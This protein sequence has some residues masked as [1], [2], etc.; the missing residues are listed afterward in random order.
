MTW[1]YIQN[2]FKR[3]EQTT[4][5]ELKNDKNKIS[6]NLLFQALV[7]LQWCSTLEQLIY[8]KKKCKVFWFNWLK[9]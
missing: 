3:K 7:K 5:I 9:F 6:K 2:I 8:S 4:S 1:V